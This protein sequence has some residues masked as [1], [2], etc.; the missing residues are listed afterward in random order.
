[1]KEKKINKLIKLNDK[2]ILERGVD[3]LIFLGH[4]LFYL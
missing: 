2:V 3:W 1:M 4:L